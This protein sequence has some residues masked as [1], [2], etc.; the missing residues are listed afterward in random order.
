MQA[1]KNLDEVAH[2]YPQNVKLLVEKDGFM[3]EQYLVYTF[4]V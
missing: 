1:A 3:A 2:G 4:N